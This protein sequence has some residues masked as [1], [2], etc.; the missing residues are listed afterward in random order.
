MEQ[1]GVTNLVSDSYRANKRMFLV[2]TLG[3][4]VFDLESCFSYAEMFLLLSGA[5]S[6]KYRGMPRLSRRPSH[7]GYYARLSDMMKADVDG[8]FYQT[9][10]LLVLFNFDSVE[11]LTQL[12][13]FPPIFCIFEL[14]EGI[15]RYKTTRAQVTP[16]SSQCPAIP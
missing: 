11:D 14:L 13:V 6:N 1:K 9:A 16:V 4:V 7:C 3:R 5:T 12:I 10:C 15:L 2:A 8:S